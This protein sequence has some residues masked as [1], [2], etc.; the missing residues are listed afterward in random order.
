MS[1]RAVWG[2]I[3]ASEERIGQ[4]LVIREGRGSR[5]TPFA[6]KLM[7]K[8]EKIQARIHNE[9]DDVFDTLIADYLEQ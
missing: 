2:R 5:L 8:Y 7:K 4:P 1:Y 6:S 3:R 9:S